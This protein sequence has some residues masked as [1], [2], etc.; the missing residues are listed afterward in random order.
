VRY[1]NGCPTTV[2]SVIVSTQHAEGV[3]F[4]DIQSYIREELVPRG[5]GDWVTFTTTVMA[6]P[7][8]Q[9]V[10]GGP[11]AD[12]SVTGRKIIVD[13]D[14]GAVAHGGGAM[15]GKDPT[16]VDRSGSYFCRY[17]ARAVVRAGLA[18]R[19]EVTVSYAI[20]R[21]EPAH[22]A[23]RTFGTGDQAGAEE[24]IRGFDFRPAA[25]IEL[26]DL[27]RPIYSSVTNY[28]H[29][30]REGLPWELDPAVGPG[31]TERAS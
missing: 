29:F 22:L 21:P 12:C 8:G 4:R 10:L 28:G 14:G 6:N 11:A 7:S 3:A 17:V 19:A 27:K 5:L 26:L 18:R 23:V 1:E 16:K 9:F 15:S 20:G 2:T 13:T 30:G 31:T 25:I 24:Y